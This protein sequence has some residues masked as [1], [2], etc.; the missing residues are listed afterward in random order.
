MGRTGKGHHAAMQHVFQA[1]KLPAGCDHLNCCEGGC[2]AA[3]NVRN[4][5]L[6]VRIPAVPP[7]RGA[8]QARNVV[9]MHLRCRVISTRARRYI[10][11]IPSG[12]VKNSSLA[13]VSAQRGTM[14]SRLTVKSTVK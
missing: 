6:P 3:P 7:P 10:P 12:T 4:R 13:T 1:A 8:P 9:G 14:Y 5:V 11:R 2:K